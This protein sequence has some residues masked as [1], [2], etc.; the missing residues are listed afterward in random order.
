MTLA[1]RIVIL[2]HGRIEQIG[3]PEEVYETPATAFVASFI[4]A[5]AMNLLPARL[6]NRQLR[7]GGRHRP[8]LPARWRTRCAVRDP[9]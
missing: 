9:A 6:E 8:A 7:P 3:T 5:P 2:N 1:D 4:G